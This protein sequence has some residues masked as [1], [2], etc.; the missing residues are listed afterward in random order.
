MLPALLLSGVAQQGLQFRVLP[1]KGLTISVAGVPV[2]RGSWVQYYDSD[3]SKAY[4]STTT[5]VQTV[6]TLDNGDTVLMFRSQDGHA[7]GNEL[8]TPTSDG[9]KVVYSFGWTGDK[10]VKIE[11][12]AAT[13]W[14]DPL[15]HGSLTIDGKSSRSLS[16][17]DYKTDEVT[18][19]AYGL[20]G[21]QFVFSA[22]VGK[23]SF[24]GLD[25]GWTCFD[26]RGSSKGWAKNQDLYWIG[27]LALDV[28][29]NEMA[30]AEVEWHFTPAAAA[31]QSGSTVSLNV[32]SLDGAVVPDPTEHPILPTPREDLLKRDQ[33]MVIGEEL[34]VDPPIGMEDVGEEIVSA[35]K[36]RFDVPQLQAT[37]SGATVFVRLENL[38]LPS[39]GYE[40]RINSRTAMIL[41]QDPEGIRNAIGTLSQIA[42]ARD[43]ELCLPSGIV[44]DWPATSWRGVHLFVGPEA[45]DF[46]QK[47]WNRVL[48]PLKFNKVVL[49]CERTK[50][51]AL[52][53][54]KPSDYMSRTDL[55]ALADYYRRHDVEVIPLIQSFG[56]MDWLL[57]NSENVDLALYPQPAYSID[58]RL[59]KA[60][61]LL[62]KVWDE[63][64]AMLHPKTIHFGLDEINLRWPTKDSDLATQLWQVQ[65][66]YLSSIASSHNCGMMCWGDQCLAPSEA[67]DAALAGTP[68]I[69]AVRRSYLPK[70]S[71]IGD[72]H[73]K[74]DPNPDRFAASL[75]LWKQEGDNPIAATW[76]NL[77]NIR[78]FYLA[79]IAAGVGTLQTT[80]AGKQSDEADMIREFR[81]FSAMVVAADYAWSGRKDEVSKL[82]YDP[83]EVFS[84]LYFEPR[85]ELSP[86][87]GQS[88]STGGTVPATIGNV[89]FNTFEPIA[90]RSM[91]TPQ[92][93]TL[94]QDITIETPGL[95][96]KT[97]ALAM[98]TTVGC[99]ENQPVA[100]VEVHLA[101]GRVK[102]ETLCYGAQ[103]RA[104]ADGKANVMGPRANGLSLVRISLGDSLEHIASI[105]LH[106]TSAYAGLRLHGVTA[107]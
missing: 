32:N 50:W 9:V 51:H 11:L 82:G 30:T 28:Q 41:G 71:M 92:S 33:P 4:F 64:I 89:K 26:A 84:R 78:G 45:L 2:V 42:F 58:P 103:V 69:A 96:G 59:P 39:G 63:A 35:L 8:F 21:K 29:P 15:Q 77:D 57:S 5:G 13:L 56:H 47:L 7:Y 100:D 27:K 49:E 81:Q 101:D 38:N 67:P 10:P 75:Q 98:D 76:F 20:N 43:G 53:N 36:A 97:L 40:M 91:L 74:N 90:L 106:G 94:P 83:A 31:A 12:A 102:T 46:H 14:T 85:E 61:T 104:T 70:G 99:D 60:K 87:S 19:R 6:K 1:D 54:P 16:S 18:E 73:Y 72:W 93:S 55:L 62:A 23:L 34:G 22:P 68:A 66:P 24:Q 95:V 44:R 37:Q 25:S 80:W 48:L 107:Y 86:I 17:A 88:A 105:S 79:A 52:P 65:V 3:W